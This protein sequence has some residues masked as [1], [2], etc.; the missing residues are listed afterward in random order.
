MRWL[1]RGAG[2]SSM[3]A[4][5][6]KSRR[7]AKALPQS[8]SVPM[9]G[10]GPSNAHW[11][12]FL[13]ALEYFLM[14]IRNFSDGHRNSV[15][16]ASEIRREELN[17]GIHRKHGKAKGGSSLGSGG[18]QKDGEKPHRVGVLKAQARQFGWVKPAERQVRQN[19][20]PRSSLWSAYPSPLGR[21]GEREVP[22]V[23]SSTGCHRMSCFVRNQR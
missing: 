16:R 23:R 11:S 19:H 14:P 20:L 8:D 1:V 9:P 21:V 5:L 13:R 18:A 17:H 22:R 7:D 2:H 3:G 12:T 4:P 15:R 6:R 10:S